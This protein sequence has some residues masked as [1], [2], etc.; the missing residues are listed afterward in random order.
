M[1]SLVQNNYTSTVDVTGIPK[2][3]ITVTVQIQDDTVRKAV[4]NMASAERAAMKRFAERGM[5]AGAANCK[6]RAA[7]YERVLTLLAVN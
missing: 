6:L 1:T 2:E 5:Y 4:E 3:S 7:A